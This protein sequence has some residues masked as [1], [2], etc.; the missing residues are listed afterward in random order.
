[1]KLITVKTGWISENSYIYYDEATLEGVVIDPGADGAK[2]I[3]AIEDNNV[4]IKAILLTHGHFD[5]IGAVP[6]IKA[7]TNA[8][9]CAHRAEAAV[10]ADNV[11]NP[12]RKLPKTPDIGEYA[13]LDDN[14][15]LE[16][17]NFK[18][19]VI[20]TPGHTVGSVCCLDRENGVLFTG[21]TLFRDSVGRTDFYTGDTDAII[22]SI[23]KR[24]FTLPPET[25]VCPGHMED[26]EIGH[27]MTN[28]PFLGGN[29][30]R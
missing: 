15:L 25:K 12:K 21:D 8:G 5:H 3:R 16:Y 6:E 7:H 23:A 30:P 18:L 28:N 29:R 9:V 1:M 24:L 17:K 10:F 19:E 27:E 11:N 13:P 22:D 20:H 4:S 14:S 2:I 26:T